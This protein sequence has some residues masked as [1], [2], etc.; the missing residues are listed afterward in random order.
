[1]SSHYFT[2]ADGLAWDDEGPA[3]VA[4]PGE[5]DSRG[6]R[7]T[8]VVAEDGGWVAFCMTA[9]ARAPPRTGTSARALRV[10]CV[11]WTTRLLWRRPTPAGSTSSLVCQRQQR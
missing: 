8:S 4:R 11:S 1:M 7:I 9:I 3:L 2:S 6:A 5:W 10:V